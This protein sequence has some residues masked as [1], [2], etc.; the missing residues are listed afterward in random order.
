MLHY[1]R[2]RW[3]TT[4]ENKTFVETFP[5]FLWV[6]RAIDIIIGSKSTNHSPGQK[7][8]LVAMIGGFRSDLSITRMTDGNFGNVSAGVLFSKVAYQ[9]KAKNFMLA[10]IQSTF[11]YCLSHIYPYMECLCPYMDMWG[12]MK[13]WPTEMVVKRI[14]HCNVVPDN[15]PTS[16]KELLF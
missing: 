16:P 3:Y 9:W 10:H 1:H 2:F 5:K 4:L 6:L 7:V 14:W 11:P 13:F 12:S 15:I 8:T